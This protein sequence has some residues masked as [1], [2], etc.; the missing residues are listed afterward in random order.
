MLYKVTPFGYFSRVTKV[1]RGPWF[2]HAN[3]E[4]DGLEYYYSYSSNG[5]KLYLVS[6]NLP[7]ADREHLGHMYKGIKRHQGLAWLTG[8]WLG[9]ETV[10]RC[11]Y[12]RRM[13]WGWRLVSVVGVGWIFKSIFSAYHA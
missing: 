6:N 12:F 10:L 4:D 3:V 13:A 9:M 11:A 2:Q 8:L 1:S 7:L 5:E